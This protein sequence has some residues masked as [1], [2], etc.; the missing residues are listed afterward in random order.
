VSKLRIALTFLIL[1]ALPLVL[2]IAIVYIGSLA[3]HA[4]GDGSITPWLI[5]AAVYATPVWALIV[6]IGLAIYLRISNRR[7]TESA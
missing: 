7:K 4:P 6:A 2:S 1:S 3:S 5:V